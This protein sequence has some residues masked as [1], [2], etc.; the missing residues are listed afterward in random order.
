MII[1]NSGQPV[2]CLKKFDLLGNNEEALSKSFAYV[3]GYEAKALF[4][5]LQYIGMPICYSERTFKRISIIT[6]KKTKEGTIDIEIKDTDKLHVIIESKIKRNRIKKQ[7]TQY[8]DSFD[9]NCNRKVLCFLTQER[10]TNKQIEKDVQIINISW[11]DINELFNNKTF[12]QRDLINEFI[13]FSIKNYQMNEQREILIQDLSHKIEITRFKEYKI[14]KRDQTFGSPLYFAPYFTR[15]GN[16]IEGEGISYLAKILGIL[17]LNPKD[18][19]HFETDLRRFCNNEITVKKWIEGVLLG[20]EDSKNIFTF[21]FLD[22]P[23]K[24]SKNLIKEGTTIKGRG[25]GWIAA[26]IPKNRCVTFQEFAKRLM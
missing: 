15:K 25:K 17:T 11:Y 23:L 20:L 12:I 6:E 26:M 22:E 5:F 21:Y 8:F 19:I 9:K 3:L 10:D 14:Y 2:S 24:L 18:I 7:R 1:K 4:K 13:N 16:L